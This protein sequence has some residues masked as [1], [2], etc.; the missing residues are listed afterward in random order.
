MKFEEIFKEEGLYVAD[1]FIKGFCFEVKDGFL[2][3]V[4]YTSATDLFPKKESQGM[5]YGLLL[6]DYKK[7]FTIKSLF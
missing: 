3:G 1:S 7:V 4:T 6:K 5:Y 2:Y